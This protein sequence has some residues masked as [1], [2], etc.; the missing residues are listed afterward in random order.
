MRKQQSKTWWLLV[1]LMCLHDSDAQ[2]NWTDK[3]PHKSGFITARLTLPAS[4]R[5]RAPACRKKTKCRYTA[6][7]VTTPH[8]A[9]R[10]AQKGFRAT[11]PVPT[12][13]SLTVTIVFYGGGCMLGGAVPALLGCAAG[14]L[15]K[16]WLF[17]R[18]EDTRPADSAGQNQ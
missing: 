1:V 13:Q 15:G 16:L 11:R 8:A 6:R 18:D 2:S 7:N 14:Q 17:R 9:A 5:Q 3:S 12:W 10:L 4:S